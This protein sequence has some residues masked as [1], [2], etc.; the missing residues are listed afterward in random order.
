MI[1]RKTTAPPE[2]TVETVE[3]PD[4]PRAPLHAYQRLETT[5][6]VLEGVVYV[7]A[8]ETETVLTPGDSILIEPGMEHRRWNAGDM[9]A[10]FTETFRTVVAS[11]SGVQELRSAAAG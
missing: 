8:G 5:I 1:A 7:V 2:L 11:A 3:P 9:D 10:V 4:G 6:R